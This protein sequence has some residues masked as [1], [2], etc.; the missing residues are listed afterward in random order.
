MI[1]IADNITQLVGNTPLVKLNKISQGLETTIIAKLEFFNPTSSVKDRLAVA[2]ID[3]AEKRGVVNQ[4]TTII[5]PTSGNTGIGL[6]FVCAQRGYKLILVMPDNM[7]VE[8]RRLLEAFNAS[9]VLTPG[10]EGMTRAC[11]EAQ[12]LH[13]KIDNSFIPDQFSNPANPA[14]HKSTTAQEIWQDSDSGVDIVVAGVGT[15]GTITGIA[16]FLHEKKPSIRI[17]AV[18]PQASPILSTG[19]KGSHKIQGI[20]AGFIPSILRKELLSEIITVTDRDAAEMTR[21]LA[22][23]EGI[24][25]GISSGAALSAAVKVAKRAENKNK[26]L[27]VVFAD[28]G[29]RYLSTWVFK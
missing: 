28:S 21:R 27:I 3:D 23:E 26:C 7:S 4:Q 15:G 2:L 1:K 29:E 22:L 6:A 14:I 11:V 19:K 17:I 20:G 24:V 10:P 5:E 9:L 18:E 16:E 25:A 8:R 12:R 13:Q